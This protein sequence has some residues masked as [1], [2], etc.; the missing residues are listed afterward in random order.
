MEVCL[1]HTIV[2][3]GNVFLN[4]YYKSNRNIFK[5]SNNIQV[6]LEHYLDP[7]KISKFLGSFINFLILLLYLFVFLLLPKEYTLVYKFS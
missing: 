6:I 4:F 7:M 2:L 1:F 5:F 3:S